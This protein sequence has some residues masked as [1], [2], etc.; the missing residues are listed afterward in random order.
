MLN[1]LQYNIKAAMWPLIFEQ[2]IEKGMRKA[3]NFSFMIKNVSNL[4]LTIQKMVAFHVEEQIKII[5]S[6][7]SEF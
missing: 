1:K 4:I 7:V 3:I 2:G 5:I 6:K